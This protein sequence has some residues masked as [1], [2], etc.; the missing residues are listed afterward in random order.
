MA[1]YALKTDTLR[2][3]AATAGDRSLYRISKR[4]GLDLTVLSRVTRGENAPSLDTVVRLAAAYGLT[5]EALLDI[6]DTQRPAA[7]TA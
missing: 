3:A 1:T 7:L 4:T 5:V 6:A 2:T